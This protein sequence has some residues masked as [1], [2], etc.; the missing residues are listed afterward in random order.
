MIGS[1]TLRVCAGYRLTE[2]LGRGGTGTVY[3]AQHERT[4]QRVAIKVLL[5]ELSKSRQAVAR[6][7]HEAR[8]AASVHD[9]GIVAV[10]DSGYAEDGSAFI[11]M[12]LLEGESLASRIARPPRVSW[13]LLRDLGV[14]IARVVG[15]AHARQIVHRDLKPDNVFLV[16]EDARRAGARVKVLDFGMAK[17]NP[18]A[19]PYSFVTEKGALIGTPMY[20]SP[21][22]CRGGEVDA[23]TD[24]YALGCM[25]YELACG[26]P[27][28]VQGGLGLILG[29]HVYS[30]VPPPRALVPELPQALEQL[31]MRTLE[32]APDKRPPSMQ[33]LSDELLGLSLREQGRVHG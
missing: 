18:D 1:A 8:S 24:I 23:R 29:A 30:P 28:F 20:M 3:A 11:V 9:P 17:L 7:F 6:F 4:G 2:E 21:E 25:L 26:H 31:L 14:E 10:Y 22:Q 13:A 32:K 16:H 15:A 12:E 5:P 33:A 27:P 19:G